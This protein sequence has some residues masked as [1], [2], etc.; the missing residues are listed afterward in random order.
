[1]P[2]QAMREEKK[3]P[4]EFIVTESCRPVT[5]RMERDEISPGTGDWNIDLIDGEMRTKKIE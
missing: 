3:G 4:A 2:G 5:P 1:M